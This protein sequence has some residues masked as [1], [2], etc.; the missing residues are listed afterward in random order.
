MGR[1]E[2][3]LYQVSDLKDLGVLAFYTGHIRIP[4][5]A[6]LYGGK[7]DINGRISD[8]LSNFKIEPI[9]P[10]MKMPGGLETGE[11]STNDMIILKH[12]FGGV[13]DI[14]KIHPD[15]GIKTQ[16]HGTGKGKDKKIRDLPY[17][18]F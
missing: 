17:S 2:Q 15:F 5:P 13:S 14:Y 6:G 3:I 10:G 4:G 18:S 16:F 12:D 11:R 7:F 9:K 1:L 8:G